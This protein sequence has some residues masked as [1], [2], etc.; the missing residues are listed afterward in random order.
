MNENLEGVLEKMF[1]IQKRYFEEKFNV[2]QRQNA[3]LWI[4]LQTHSEKLERLESYLAGTTES[5]EGQDQ[6]I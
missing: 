2:L 5:N 1:S 4:I 6:V 3:D